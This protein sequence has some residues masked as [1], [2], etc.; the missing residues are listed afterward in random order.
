MRI[1]LMFLLIPLSAVAQQEP[2]ETFQSGV[3]MIQ[4]PVVVR[5]HDGHVVGDLAKDDFKLF[6][7]GKPVEI[8]NFSVEKPG[9]QVAP[10]RSL[11]DPNAPAKKSAGAAAMD[12]PERFIAYFFDDVAIRNFGD[13][14]R[15][16]EAAAQQFSSLEPGD[17]AALLTSS[18]TLALDF[19]NDRAKLQDTVA[20]LQ[21]HPPRVCRVSTIQSLQLTLLRNIVR[22]M[23][24]LPGQRS[25]ILVSSGFQVALDRGQEEME[26]IE[27]AIR[28]KVR[29]DSLDLGEGGQ[30]A[31]SGGAEQPTGQQTGMVEAA[32]TE[33]STTNPIV[34]T[35]LARGTGGTYLT[36]NNYVASFHRL[37]TPESHYVLSFVSTAKPDGHLHQLKVKLAKKGKLTVEARNSYYASARLP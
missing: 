14:K 37:A 12:I 3:T 11:P 29:I 31:V 8:A 36:G 27:E 16:R 1:L 35:D 7:N 24:R 6:D 17:R 25:I 23:S 19:T 34:L 30:P 18:C 22:G 28:S 21:A 33:S 15:L 4:V 13:L 32:R 10:D 9:G 2:A 26:L 20:R 5:D